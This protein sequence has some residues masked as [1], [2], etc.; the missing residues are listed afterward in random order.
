MSK[1]LSSAFSLSLLKNLQQ[2]LM[3]VHIAAERVNIFLCWLIEN[4]EKKL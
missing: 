1:H 4:E 3:V 2:L